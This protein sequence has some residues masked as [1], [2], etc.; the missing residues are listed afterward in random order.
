[1]RRKP[2][3]TESISCSRAEPSSAC[4]ASSSSQL[5]VAIFLPVRG[6]RGPSRMT[7]GQRRRRGTVEGKRGRAGAR[8]PQAERIAA[9][10]APEPGIGSRPCQEDGGAPRFPPRQS[11]PRSAAAEG[12]GRREGVSPVAAAAASPRQCSGARCPPSAEQ[13]RLRPRSTQRE[14][15]G[16]GAGHVDQAGGA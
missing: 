5:R 1:M 15:T 14:A 7:P 4:W 13:W 11:R 6:A 9:A 8:P 3:P 16:A 2:R 12:G 10:L